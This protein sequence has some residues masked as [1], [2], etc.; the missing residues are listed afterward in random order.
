M[1]G[2]AA[3][4]LQAVI[5]QNNLSPLPP[6]SSCSLLGC[7]KFDTKPFIMAEQKTAAL[8]ITWSKQNDFSFSYNVVKFFFF[9]EGIFRILW[10]LALSF[11]NVLI[12]Y[13]LY[14]TFL[15]LS[16]KRPRN[17]ELF[18]LLKHVRCKKENLTFHPVFLSFS[19]QNI[20]W[21]SF[22]KYFVATLSL[23]EQRTCMLEDTWGLLLLSWSV[24][25]KCSLSWGNTELYLFRQQ[26]KNQP[27]APRATECLLVLP[28][29]RLQLSSLCAWVHSGADECSRGASMLFCFFDL[30]SG[31]SLCLHK[32]TR[33][34]RLVQ[35]EEPWSL[36]VQIIHPAVCTLWPRNRGPHRHRK[37][38]HC[39]HH[40]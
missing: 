40:P 8:M 6:D 22:Y 28:Y 13:F 23:W 15:L 38:R 11:P 29:C 4:Y 34:S 14:F 2:I 19:Y 21:F 35:F 30:C 31:S 33:V 10:R 16:C 3:Y 26:S 7:L 32:S 1:V 18:L 9:K 24:I 17:C 37:Q 27:H 36:R 20:K 12:Y 5:T 25:L 39:T